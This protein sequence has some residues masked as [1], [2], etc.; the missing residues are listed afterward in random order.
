MKKKIEEVFF[1]LLGMIGFTVALM[2]LLAL[3]EM[4]ERFAELFI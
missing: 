3:V 2:I 4:G 1:L